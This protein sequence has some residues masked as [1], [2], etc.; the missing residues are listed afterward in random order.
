MGQPVKLLPW[1]KKIIRGIYDSPTRRAIISF[2]RKNGKTSLSAFLCLLHL[3]GPM[4]RP[5]SQLYSAAQ[6]REQAGVLFDLMV[7]TVRQ[8]AE[9]SAVIGIRESAKQLYC[10]ERGTMYR[11]LSAESTTAY[12]LSPVF[13]VHD[14]LGQVIGPRF[15]LYDA[16]ETAAGAQE[17]PLSVVISTQAANDGDLFSVLIDD[18]AAAHDPETKLFMYSAPENLD[19][20]SDKAIKAANPAYGAFLNTKEVR[21]TAEAAR[22]MPSQEASYRNLILNQRIAR[23]SPFVAQS[24]WM[25]CGKEPRSEDFAQGAVM[26]LDLSRRV[27][28][29]AL[30]MVGKGVDGEWSVHSEFFAPKIGLRERAQHDRVPY[31]LW[32][33]QGYLTLTPDQ[34]VGYDFVAHRMVELCEEYGIREIRFDRWG[35]PE[36]KTQLGLIGADDLPLEPHGQGFKDMSP[37]LAA[38]E[39]EL[40]NQ[41]LRH[42]NHPILTWCAAN[43]VADSDPAGNRK[44]NKKKATGRIDGMVALAM[45]IGGAAVEEAQPPPSPWE[46][47]NFSI[48]G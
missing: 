41:R 18:A 10:E 22:R 24:V 8:S 4:S 26:G 2:G 5:N 38:L 25:A 47:E 39:A 14:E 11:A 9:L 17:A 45:A 33:E 16:L 6:S 19:P 42:G 23:E 36:L 35:I 1:Q 40:L 44:L 32:A 12:G 15:P 29:T 3:V 34:T 13:V 30:V 37:A 7:K 46:D 43:A 21:S 28:L 20:F 27:D 31:D 48:L